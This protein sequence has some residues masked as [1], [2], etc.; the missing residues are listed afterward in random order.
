MALISY[1]T[2]IHFAYGALDLAADECARLNIRRPL[3]VTDPGV[4]QA[5]LPDRLTAS[6]RNPAAPVIFDQTPANPTESATRAAAASFAA[7]KCDGIIALGGGSSI[8]LGK[9]GSIA[10]THPGPLRAFALIENGMSK[11]TSAVCPLIAI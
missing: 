5:G 10:A 11:I 4:R 9:G 8:D 6:L 2:Q 1:L 3:I 7:E